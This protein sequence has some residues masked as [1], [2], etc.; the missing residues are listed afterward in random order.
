MLNI[1][2]LSIGF[3]R[4]HSLLRQETV[5]YLSGLTLTLHPG[6]VL[7]VIGGSGAGKSLLAHALLGLLPPNAVIGGE[8]SFRGQSLM[9]YPAELR[10][11]RIALMPQQV[12]HLDPLAR[13]GRQVGWAARRVGAIGN[14]ATQL[15]ALGL[16]PVAARLYPGQLSG[17]MARRVLL[18]MAGA[19]APDLLVADEPTVGL[20]PASRDTVLRLLRSH[21]TADRAVL[22]ITHDLATVLR[23]ADRVAILDAGHMLGVETARNFHGDGSAL[24]S[25]HARALW[26]A[27]PENGFLSDA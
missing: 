15:A 4:Y 24:I 3:R 18:A 13:T 5:T 7:A 22:L 14:A 11:R 21:A 12:A 20:D 26:R 1:R 19:G 23:F 16:P 9:P 17:G 25:S 8:M 6:E 10:G 2:D 27:L